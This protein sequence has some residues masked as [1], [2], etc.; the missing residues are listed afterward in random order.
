MCFRDTPGDRWYELGS[1]FEEL[2]V[3]TERDLRWR[4]KD[5]GRVGS[6]GGRGSSTYGGFVG[7]VTLGTPPG[8]GSS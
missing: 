7:V 1:F 8:T 2:G 3:V 4:R 6:N 5:D